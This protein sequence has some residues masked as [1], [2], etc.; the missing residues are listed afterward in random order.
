VKLEKVLPHMDFFF[1]KLLINIRRLSF[2][3]R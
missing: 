1:G 2:Y 3:Y